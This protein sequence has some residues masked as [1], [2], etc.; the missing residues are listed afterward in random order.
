MGDRSQIIDG[1]KGLILSL[2]WTIHGFVMWRMETVRRCGFYEFGINSDEFTTRVLYYMSNRIA[3]SE[4]IFYY[5]QNNINAITKKWN[6]RQLECFNTSLKLEEFL[7]EKEFSE[8]AIAL[9]N[10]IIFIDLIRVQLMFLDNRRKMAEDDVYIAKK[11]IKNIYETSQSKIKALK[12]T[13]LKHKIMH[14]FVS[15]NYNSFI[16]FVA[17]YRKFLSLSNGR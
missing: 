2:D 14:V 11:A 1:R 13:S 9:A 5:R 15:A 7:L 6:I 17:M 12:Y 8:E 16:A 3:F 10:K 4:G